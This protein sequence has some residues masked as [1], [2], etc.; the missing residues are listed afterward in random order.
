MVVSAF[1]ARQY[2]RHASLGIQPA[3][4]TGSSRLAL[5]CAR[6]LVVLDERGC[7]ISL[8]SGSQSAGEL[9]QNHPAD[10]YGRLA[11]LEI[12][13]LHSRLLGTPDS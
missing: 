12:E 3:R 7:G 6:T 9:A 5:L 13:R 4:A 8:S 2:A 11:G 1:M 10:L